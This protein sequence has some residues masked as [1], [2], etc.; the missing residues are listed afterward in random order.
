MCPRFIFLAQNIVGIDL[1]QLMLGYIL[2]KSSRQQVLKIA[3]R[4][5]KNRDELLFLISENVKNVLFFI[6]PSYTIQKWLSPRTNR[7]SQPVILPV[8]Q[9]LVTFHYSCR[10]ANWVDIFIFLRKKCCRWDFRRNKAVHNQTGPK[11]HPLKNLVKM[12]YTQ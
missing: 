5:E 8:N 10:S 4:L 3:V 12:S 1:S 11:F 6:L 2:K 9:F 7:K